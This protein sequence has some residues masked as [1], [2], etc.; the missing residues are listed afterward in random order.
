[1]NGRISKI[2]KNKAIVIG[3]NGMSFAI[4]KD[5]LHK[6]NPPRVNNVRKSQNTFDIS[7]GL[8]VGLELNIIGL[9]VEEAKQ[10]LIKY[11]DNCRLKHF[12]QVRI[13][14]GYGSGALRKMT[15]EYL[16]TQKDCKYRPGDANEGGGGAT[17][18]IFK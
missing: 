1:M 15:R 10:E 4:S 2:E 17:V 9:R 8:N 18:V 7:L 6:I 3:D 5:K 16:D 14:H 13:I 11:I 12:N